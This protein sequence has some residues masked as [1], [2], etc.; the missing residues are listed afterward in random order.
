MVRHDA[1]C[2]KL[3]KASMSV[4]KRKWTTSKG[5]A[6]EAWIVDYT[7]Q[8]GDRCLETFEKKKDADAR[9]AV[10]AV[11][12]TSGTHVAPSKSITIKQAG[13]DW[14]SAC[15]DL[16]RGT[17]VQ[18]RQHLS[19]IVHHLGRVKLCDFTPPM[20]T[21]FE[22]ALRGEGVSPVMVKK[23]RTSLG[24]LL[25]SAQEHGMVGRNIVRELGRMR[26]GK[27]TKALQQRKIKAGEDFPLPAEVSRILAHA[28]PRWRPLLLVAAFTGLRA[29]ELRGLRWADVDLKSS[30]LH[31]R[32]R[33]DCFAKID[34]PKSE[35]G[36]RTVPFGSVVM[37][38][39][40]EWKL[41]SPKGEMD[42]VF[43]NGN[44]HVESLP[45]IIARGLKPACVAAGV[46]D[47][48]GA[49]KYTGMHTLR[50][51]YA[52]WCINRRVDGGR[53]LPPKTVQERLGHSKITLT[54]DVY[55]HLFPAA[56]DDEIDACE[57]ALVNAT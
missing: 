41:R 12:I 54:L 36:E 25:A 49:A 2:Y 29:S 57:L 23:I 4:R 52:S 22:V 18:Y 7:D 51:F 55:G 33:A 35:A 21:K 13:D 34:A 50:H 17:F 6:R 26:K 9:H 44:G 20:L 43:P 38:T 45:N 31:V 3:V 10:V 53:E 19:R 37:N 27:R 16:E 5:E 24:S 39:L 48:D 40:K 56:A 11:G 14:L 15:S 30:K 32:Q 1:D 46:V 47:K 28:K 42:L 8:A